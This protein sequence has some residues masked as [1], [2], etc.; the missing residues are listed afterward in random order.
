VA[1][2]AEPEVVAEMLPREAEAQRPVAPK[3][4]RR[5]YLNDNNL[6]TKP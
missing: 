4:G 1:A 5:P 6:Q 2:A 3:T